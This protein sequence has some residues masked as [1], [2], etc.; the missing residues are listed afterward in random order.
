MFHR[1]FPE[2]K[3]SPSSLQRF[4]KKNKITFKFIQKIKKHINF[5]NQEY[6]S[7]F[8][9]MVA[10]IEQVKAQGIPLV[11]LDEAVFT[12]NT[13]KTKAW[14]SAYS[15]IVVR[16]Y[17]IRIKTQALIGAISIEDGM[18]E[19]AIH[20]KSIKTEEFQAFIK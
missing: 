2:I 6:R 13:F 9:R 20:P 15:N 10:E 18:V 3:I 16:D 5:H 7:M 1:Q 19:Y 12:F 17:A 8:D 11:F 4:Y 14:S